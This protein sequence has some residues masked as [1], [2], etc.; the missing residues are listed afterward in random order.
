[1]TAK[2]ALLAIVLGLSLSMIYQPRATGQS[3]T[4]S[5]ENE[6]WPE[7][8]AHV[9]LPSNW[10]VLSWIGGEKAAGYPFWQWYVGADIARQFKPILRPHWENI[11]PDKERYLVVDAGYQ[12]LRTAHAGEQSHENRITF[13][14][15]PS[16]RPA[17]NLFFRDRN[18]VELR[19][20]DGNYSTT[21][22]NLVAAEVDLRVHDIRFTP[23]GTVEFFYDSTK[24]SWDQE[25]Y[26]GGLQLPYKRVFMLEIYYRHEHC[27]TCTPE[28]WN[29]GGI[30]LNFFFKSGEVIRPENALAGYAR[31]SLPYA[32][33]LQRNSA[34]ISSSSEACTFRHHIHIYPSTKAG[35]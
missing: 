19:W 25:W 33:Q 5:T 22:R 6:A 31:H 29:V 10:R 21:Y 30:T 23:F 20:I 15:T 9:Q 35:I 34:D 32:T 28:N 1:M 2:S 11:D 18:R 4:P 16:L 26:T 17:S 27:P 7:A 8:D 3:A 12:Y 14:M 13:D 24:H